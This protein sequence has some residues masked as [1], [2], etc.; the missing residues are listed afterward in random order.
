MAV[1]VQQRATLL[2]FQ[3][4]W[5][6]EDSFRFACRLTFSPAFKRTVS[7]SALVSASVFKKRPAMK[8]R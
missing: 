3:F 8:I 4:A 7:Q 1:V 5:R 2:H 6:S